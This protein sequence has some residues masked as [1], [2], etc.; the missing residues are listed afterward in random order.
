MPKLEVLAILDCSRIN[1]K[2]TVLQSSFPKSGLHRH[3][4]DARPN[5]RKNT[6]TK[7]PRVQNESQPPNAYSAPGRKGCKRGGT[8]NGIGPRRHTP[9][10]ENYSPS[11]LRTRW[12]DAAVTARFVGWRGGD[13]GGGEWVAHNGPFWGFF[14]YVAFLGRLCL[15]VFVFIFCSHSTRFPLTR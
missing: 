9:T 1:W 2:E 7:Q 12:V 10:S 13:D 11:R 4:A 5:W 3:V 8:S 6:S 15:C 14:F